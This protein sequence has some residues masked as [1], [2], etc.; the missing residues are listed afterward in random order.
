MS[1][2]ACF[3]AKKPVF[4]RLK[5]LM[6]RGESYKSSLLPLAFYAVSL[7]RLRA[8]PVHSSLAI[9]LPLPFRPSP[10]ECF[11]A[12]VRKQG[13]PAMK[14]VDERRSWLWGSTA[15]LSRRRIRSGGFGDGCGR[16]EQLDCPWRGIL[17]ILCD[18]SRMPTDCFLLARAQK[19]SFASPTP[20]CVRRRVKLSA[21]FPQALFSLP[22][23]AA[24]AAFANI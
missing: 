6:E 15:N 8:T 16:Y 13:V 23:R 20:V 7:L 24:L 4:Q 10:S 22:S 1:V 11:I 12:G 2:F 3:F 5:R 18:G 9:F 21:E 19:H 17:S 14:C